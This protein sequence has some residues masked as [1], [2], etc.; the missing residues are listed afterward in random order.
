MK[1]TALFTLEVTQGKVM[2][3]RLT[4]GVYCLSA[5]LYSQGLC[6]DLSVTNLGRQVSILRVVPCPLADK[7]DLALPLIRSGLTL[8]LDM[9]LSC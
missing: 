1:L 7:R 9:I 8:C 5:S 2:E 3:L 4:P 6:W